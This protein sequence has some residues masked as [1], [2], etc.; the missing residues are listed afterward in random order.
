[1]PKKD[2][3]IVGAGP[4]GLF[5][6][7]GIVNS[8]KY[9]NNILSIHVFDKGKDIYSR[10]CPMREKENTPCVNCKP[11]CNI[12]NGFGGA[13]TFSDCKL[14][15]TPFGVGGDIIDYIS[16]GKARNLI[17]TVDKIFAKFDENK[18]NRKVYGRIT[19]NENI[20]KIKSLCDCFGVSFTECPT[21]HLGT[22]GTYKIMQNLY[23]YL[24]DKGVNFY[25]NTQVDLHPIINENNKTAII[26]TDV[27]RK[28]QNGI[29]NVDYVVFAPGRSGNS[30][31]KETMDKVGIKTKHH[32]VDIGVRVET[33][34]DIIKF[35]TDNLY[36]MKL[37]WVDPKTG[38]KIRTFCTNPGGYVSE[39]YYNEEDLAIV[40]G[41]S[42]TDKKSDNS[43]FALLVTLNDDSLDSNYAKQI[44]KLANDIADGG[45]IKQTYENFI[46]ES[47]KPSFI[48]PTLNSAKDRDL[49]LVLPERI[50]KTIKNFISLLDCICPGLASNNTILYG[51]ETK[52]YSDTIE[53][54]D[55]MQTLIP[56]IYCTGDGAG[57]TRGIVQASVSGL[58]VAENIINEVFV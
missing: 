29:W 10:V 28:V 7:L 33:K 1:M 56:G 57:I 20:Q 2:V 46:G 15:L 22:D 54:N 27:K 18:T 19:E 50:T 31:L 52:F 34:K 30:W 6:A 48:K 9:D 8:P 4:A 5:T 11:Y 38:D 24:L 55:N 26:I 42:F 21:K 14:S 36:D 58:I 49:N 44:A 32:K 25:F 35:L 12:M 23:Q 51:V 13:G 16:D 41:H 40:N 45:L 37:S 43:N 17:S 3:V 39:E 53:V 47:N